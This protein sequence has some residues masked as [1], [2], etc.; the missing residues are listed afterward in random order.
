MF[1]DGYFQE[2][3]HFLLI[4]YIKLIGHFADCSFISKKKLG[5]E[6]HTHT[7]ISITFTAAAE[8]EQNQWKEHTY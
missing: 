1:K 5:Q 7:E 6:K 4:G 2:E 3:W 8:G